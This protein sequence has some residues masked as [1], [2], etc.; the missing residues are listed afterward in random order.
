MKR[1][2]GFGK[3]DFRGRGCKVNKVTVGI[4][5]SGGKKPSLSI[6][7]DV[8]NQQ[9]TDIV[10][11]GQCLDRLLPFFRDNK[12]FKE[13]FRLW[14]KCNLNDMHFGT[15]EQEN[16]LRS[17]GFGEPNA[18]DYDRHCEALKNAGLYEVEVDGKPFK[19]GTRWLYWP[20]ELSDMASILSLITDGTVLDKPLFK[21][22][23]A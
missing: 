10:I 14:R 20:I 7:A 23:E 16:W 2:I 4:E 12:I 21:D 9:E 8:W 19:Y 1:T 22:E 15:P 13:I 3:I 17:H 5:L 18:N 11:G 6:D